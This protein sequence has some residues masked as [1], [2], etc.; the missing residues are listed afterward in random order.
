MLLGYHQLR[1]RSTQL[2]LHRGDLSL[3]L[4]MAHLSSRGSRA[5]GRQLVQRGRVLHVQLGLARVQ[6]REHRA[7][8]RQL[9]GAALSLLLRGRQ[10]ALDAEHRGLQARALA[11]KVR[12]LLLGAGQRAAARSR[13]RVRRLAV[14]Q[15]VRQ[16]GLQRLHVGRHLPRLPLPRLDH[17]GARGGQAHARRVQLLQLAADLRLLQHRVCAGGAHE[18]LQAGHQPLHLGACGCVTLHQGQHLLR[19]RGGR[20]G[21]AAHLHLVGAAAGTRTVAGGPAHAAFCTRAFGYIVA[22]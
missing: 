15:R 8:L 3:C 22:C 18:L 5:C 9:G 20:A 21:R 17:Q 11:L 1:L 12:Q 13:Q 14:V 4:G 6:L 2:L 7:H 16:A 10:L 19:Q